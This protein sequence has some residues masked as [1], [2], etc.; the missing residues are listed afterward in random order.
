M[1]FAL[2]FTLAENFS[3]APVDERDDGPTRGYE[4]PTT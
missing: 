1:F 2:S 3:S 4:R